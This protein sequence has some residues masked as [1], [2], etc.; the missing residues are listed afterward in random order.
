MLTQLS[1]GK[2]RLR[3]FQSTIV[4]SFKRRYQT[5]QNHHRLGVFI[6]SLASPHGRL[7]NKALD[8]VD[9]GMTIDTR[10]TPFVENTSLV[11]G[12]SD[13][14]RDDPSVRMPLI[15]SRRCITLVCRTFST[16]LQARSFS[17]SRTIVTPSEAWL[18]SFIGSNTGVATAEGS[19]NKYCGRFLSVIREIPAMQMIKNQLTCGQGVQLQPKI[20]T[21]GFEIE[22]RRAE[23]NTKVNTG[24]RDLTSHF[25]V[26][27]R[28]FLVL[29]P[30]FVSPAVT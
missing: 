2:K 1:I 26:M 30:F 20:K 4:W 5:F 16:P 24:S 27:I 9:V 19:M 8:S 6:R 18:S 29:P 28:Y 12:L 17:F 14:Y 7:S 22:Y 15:I 11:F 10:L 3:G 13:L 21:L 23:T 25:Q